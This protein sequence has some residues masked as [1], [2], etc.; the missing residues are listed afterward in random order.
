MSD[1]P[2]WLAFGERAAYLPEADALVLAD[3]HVG[4]D[5]ASDVALPLG[6][7]ADLVERLD[8]L[9]AEFEP[10]TVVV[11]GDLLHVHGSVPEGVRE[12]VGAIEAAVREADA[13][14]RVVR[15]N[16]D[17]MLDAV[18]IDA[19]ESVVLADGTAIWHGH[20]D[21]PVDAERYVV[22]HEHPAVEIEGARHPCFLYGP[23]QHDGS[24][25]V[26][27]PAFTRLAP[28]TLVNG[29]RR[30]DS[31]SSMLSDPSGFRPV[32]VSDG[33]TLAFPALGEFR[34]LL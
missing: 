24:D 33:E 12:T 11:A 9:L 3:V 2:S 20:D 29:L 32:V 34:G 13:T 23:R 25:V 18:G 7:R 22:G 21:P 10:A 27:L 1:T 30:D 14:F 17:A 8:A 5:A 6:E 4:R 16:H 15:G 31:L 26:V 28:G 19:E